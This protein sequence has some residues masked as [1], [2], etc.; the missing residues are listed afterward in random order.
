MNNLSTGN[1]DPIDNLEAGFWWKTSSSRCIRRAIYFYF[2]RSFLN[3]GDSIFLADRHSRF[4]ADKIISTPQICSTIR[5]EIHRTFYLVMNKIIKKK[6]IIYVNVRVRFDKN[7][8]D[9]VPVSSVC[10]LNVFDLEKKKSL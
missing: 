1:L 10:G 4:H 6:L 2:P 3:Y 9:H 7:R 8:I 5:C